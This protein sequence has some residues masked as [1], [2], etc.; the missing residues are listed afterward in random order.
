MFVFR[1]CRLVFSQSLLSLNIIEDFLDEV[2]RKNQEDADERRLKAEL[3][4]KEKLEKKKKAAMEADGKEG[5]KKEGDDEEKKEEEKKEKK[6]EEKKEE[7]KKE[8]EKKE[9]DSDEEDDE[10]VTWHLNTDYKHL[11]LYLYKEHFVSITSLICYTLDSSLLISELLNTLF[12]R[13]VL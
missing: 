6:E 1:P 10:Q 12:L 7:E 3:K 8:E 13:F 11:G 9:E 2:D 4:K 5:E